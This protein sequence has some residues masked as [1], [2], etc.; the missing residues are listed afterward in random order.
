MTNKSALLELASR[1]EAAEKADE[2]LD[3]D[4]WHAVGRPNEYLVRDLK[5]DPPDYTAS[6]DAA[7]RLVPEG[8]SVGLGDLRGRDPVVWRAHL[9][10]HNDPDEMKRQWVEGHAVTPALAL[11]AAALRALA[12]EKGE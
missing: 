5:L 3:S 11:T 6:L 10:D 8:W 12:K 2:M 9:R 7:I 4:I 1:C